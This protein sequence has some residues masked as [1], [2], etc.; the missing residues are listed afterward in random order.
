MTTYGQA[1]FE[2][3]GLLQRRHTTSVKVSTT[4]TNHP[5]ML[6]D[7]E[8]EVDNLNTEVKTV[9]I[10]D[11]DVTTV[12]RSMETG[13]REA[14]M[15]PKVL[16]KFLLFCSWQCEVHFQ[17]LQVAMKMLGLNPSDQE[18]LDIP[19]KI[20]RN[21]LIYFPDF[22]QI[23][24]EYFRQDREHE[25]DFMKNMFKVFVL[26]WY[27]PQESIFRFFVEQSLYQQTTE[28][29]SIE[30]TNIFY[31]RQDCIENRNLGLN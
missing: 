26:Q 29:R 25:E 27:N 3:L 15:D 5:D 24:L 6:T 19:N 13:L 2:A 11:Q 21:G 23:C 14:T 7:K 9:E 31:T 30:L 17:D 16:K 20:S 4:L 8:L 28:Q 10:I 1:E 12:F 22:C 18:L